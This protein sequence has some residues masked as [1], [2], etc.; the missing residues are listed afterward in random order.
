MLV[1]ANP[2]CSYF[3]FIQPSLLYYSADSHSPPGLVLVLLVAS[4]V[5]VLSTS[6]SFSSIRA[7]NVDALVKDYNNNSVSN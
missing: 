2:Y 6:I 7:L 5:S 1:E 3:S 4:L